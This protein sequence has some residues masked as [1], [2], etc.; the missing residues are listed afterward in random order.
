LRSSPARH[1]VRPPRQG[2][3]RGRVEDLRPARPTAASVGEA[4]ELRP[5]RASSRRAAAFSRAARRSAV[6]ARFSAAA[7]LPRH[8]S[9]SWRAASVTACW[10]ATSLRATCAARRCTSGSASSAVFRALYARFRSASL[11]HC[12]GRPTRLTSSDMCFR[13]VGRDETGSANAGGAATCKSVDYPGPGS[14]GPGGP[15]PSST[16]RFVVDRPTTRESSG[17]AA[18]NNPPSFGCETAMT[19]RKAAARL[20]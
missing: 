11:A 18:A 6:P 2:A 12:C 8:R 4:A 10:A 7:A 20:R 13:I 3:H 16:A 1:T 5:A 19:R 9:A 14:T 15:A 17:L